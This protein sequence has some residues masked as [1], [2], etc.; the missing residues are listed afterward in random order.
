MEM[1]KG[2]LMFRF[3]LR[4]FW[5][6]SLC[7]LVLVL[8]LARAGSAQV[9]SFSGYFDVFPDDGVTMV[10]AY[11]SLSD[12]STGCS[13]GDYVPYSQLFSPTRYDSEPGSSAGLSYSGEDGTWQVAGSFT[14][15]CS[16][17]NGYTAGGTGQTGPISSVLA[18]YMFHSEAE[19][20][21]AF[22]DRCEAGNCM[23]VH[24]NK[25]RV[26]G[27]PNA[28]PYAVFNVVRIAVGSVALCS[29]TYGY[30]IPGC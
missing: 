15:Y 1:E 14:F 24:V 3:T 4:R 28:P 22:F 25:Q 5:Q 30:G 13:H 7:S 18:N 23:Q 21:W 8:G 6:I 16:C 20:G 26:F 17:I 19:A 11:T 12:N 2:E 27:T 10:Y 29:V 9:M